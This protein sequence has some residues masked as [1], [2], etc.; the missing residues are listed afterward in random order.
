MTNEI[1]PELKKVWAVELNLLQ[2]L[3]CVLEKYNIPYFASGGTL[4]GA[5]RHGGFIPWDDDIDIMM[6]REDFDRLCAV[7]PNEFEH[8]YFFQ[9]FY[10]DKGYF[11]GHAQLRNSL[12][13]AALP[14]EALKVPFNQ[15][16][17]IDIFPL[18]SVP[19]N[20]AVFKAQCRRLNS[21][22]RLLNNSA[23]ISASKNR[24]ALS[25]LKRAAAK[26]ISVFYKSEKQY[27][28]MENICREHSAEATR[29]VAPLSFD[30]NNPRFW[31]RRSIFESAVDFPF[32]H[33]V[34]KCPAGFDELLSQQYGD[35]KVP[36]RE[37][38]YHGKVLFDTETPYGEYI[39]GLKIEK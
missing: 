24:S 26:I 18:D 1:R 6:L 38:S 15:G 3:L 22:N 4:L 20:E 31:W 16:I 28:K 21:L 35:Y 7:A 14:A 30:P 34:L 39:K 36:R 23:R 5:V 25:L 29:R 10:T 32:E 9:T 12:T 8:P 13:T 17:F 37:E 27:I 19:N 33:L 11:R 2:K